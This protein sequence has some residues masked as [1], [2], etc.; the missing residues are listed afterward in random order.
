MDALIRLNARLDQA[1]E[2]RTPN[3]LY[4]PTITSTVNRMGHGKEQSVL[5]SKIVSPQA[6]I[7]PKKVR[8]MK[9]KIARGTFHPGSLPELALVDGKYVTLAGNHR[10]VSHLRSGKR[11]V[12]ALVQ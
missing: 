9:D 3:P 5:I 12:K 8:S 10:I 11:I 2:F 6:T 4:D 7:S 1:I